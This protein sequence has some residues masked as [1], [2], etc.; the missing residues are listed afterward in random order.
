M[1]NVGLTTGRNIDDLVGERRLKLNV[2]YHSPFSRS[3]TLKALAVVRVRI[4]EFNDEIVIDCL[5]TDSSTTPELSGELA[6]EILGM[7]YDKVEPKN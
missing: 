7:L 5:G 1:L 2:L 6:L 4:N 3:A